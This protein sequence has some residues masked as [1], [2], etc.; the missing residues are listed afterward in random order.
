MDFGLEAE[1]RPS[2]CMQY[3]P[4][5]HGYQQTSFESTGSQLHAGIP[6]AV[7]C[8]ALHIISSPEWPPQSTY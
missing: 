2:R 3:L 7:F 8:L 6:L 1:A 4:T 5:A